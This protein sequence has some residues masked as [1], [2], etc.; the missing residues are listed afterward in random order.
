MKRFILAV[1]FVCL[2]VA[3]PAFAA[4]TV[5]VSV[6]SISFP[7]NQMV[8]KLTCTGDA[9]NGT[10]PATQITEAMVPKSTLGLRAEYYQ[11]GYYLFEVKVKA[12]APAPDAAD[13]AITDG[14]GAPLYSE[15]NVIPASGS[16]IG[17]VDDLRAITSKLTVTQANQSTAS[18]VWYVY[19]TFIK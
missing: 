4:G 3:G 7:G 6:E 17:V 8:L 11:L 13:I 10:V 14:T 18:A 19:L 12:G 15:A 9:A 2:I 5:V 1:V 16:K